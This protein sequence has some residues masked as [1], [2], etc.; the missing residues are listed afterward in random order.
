MVKTNPFKVTETILGE[1]VPDFISKND[2]CDTII[3]KG[4]AKPGEKEQ[5]TQRTKM[6]LRYLTNNPIEGWSV[7][8]YQNEIYIDRK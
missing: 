7:D 6:Y 3:I 5:I 2:W 1:I 8:R 4:L